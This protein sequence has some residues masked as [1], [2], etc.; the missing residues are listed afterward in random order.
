METINTTASTVEATET[1]Q[2]HAPETSV[3]PSC[4]H[5]C[6]TVT[7]ISQGSRDYLVLYGKLSDACAEFRRL[8]IRDSVDNESITKDAIT[9]FEDTMSELT[10]TVLAEFRYRVQGNLDRVDCTEI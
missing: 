10:C 8:K 3:N 4:E 1:N 5:R 7:A 9:E 2:T 6:A